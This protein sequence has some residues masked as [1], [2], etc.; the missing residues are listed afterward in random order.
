MKDMAARLKCSENS[1][2]FLGWK[3]CRNLYLSICLSILF[4]S[5]LFYSILF[6]SIP[7]YSIPFHSILFNSI[8]FHS[9][10]SICLFVSYLSIWYIHQIISLI[11]GLERDYSTG[12]V[13]LY[14]SMYHRWNRLTNLMNQGPLFKGTPSAIQRCFFLIFRENSV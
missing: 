9:I 3:G 5:L 7:F 2:S 10:L 14:N 1:D 4:S 12:R 13:Y 11:L 8:Q 6:Y